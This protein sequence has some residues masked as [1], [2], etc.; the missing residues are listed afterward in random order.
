[1]QHVQPNKNRTIDC[2]HEDNE[3]LTSPI[4]S[5]CWCC[6]C[7][8]L[9]PSSTKDAD[10]CCWHV[11]NGN[12][13]WRVRYNIYESWGINIK[14]KKLFGQILVPSSLMSSCNLLRYCQQRYVVKCSSKKWPGKY[15]AS[16]HLNDISLGL[17]DTAGNGSNS[18]GWH[19]SLLLLCVQVMDKLCKILYKV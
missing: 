13:T 4:F 17:S 12:K 8:M 19:T 18:D 9:L 10:P 3:T 14:I 15:I 5:R 2:M 7:L 16:G 6:R 11:N 1:M